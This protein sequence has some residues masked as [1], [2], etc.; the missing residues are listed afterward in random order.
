MGGARLDKVGT[1]RSNRR[2]ELGK[3]DD[4]AVGHGSVLAH[5]RRGFNCACRVQMATD[6]AQIAGIVELH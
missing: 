1:D 6:S 4:E 3:C 5:G 2:V